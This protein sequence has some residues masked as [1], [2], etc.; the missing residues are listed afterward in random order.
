MFE[1]FELGKDERDRRYDKVRAGMQERGLGALVVYG[2]AGF[3]SSE[4][5]SFVYLTNISTF[6]CLAT[7][8]YLVFPSEGEPTMIG[9]AKF[10]GEKLWVKDIRGKGA[11]YSKAIL[12][13]L[14]E[15]H[16]EK[17]KIGMINTRVVGVGST[18]ER[19]F[20]YI[21]YKYLQDNLPNAHIEDATDIVDMARRI[22]SEA[23]IHCLE[24]GCVAAD[25]GVQAVIET[26]RP[27]V[28][29][30]EVMAKLVNVL[31]LHGCEPDTLFLYGS[32]KDYVDSGNGQFLNPG[33]RRCL[34]AGDMIHTEFNAKYNNYCAQYNQPFAIGE[35]DKEWL[36]VFATAEACVQNGMQE[37]KPGIT[38]KDLAKAL[39]APVEPAG[40]KSLRPCCHGLGLTSEEPLGMPGQARC[41]PDDSFL[42]QENMVF[43]FEPH[44]V[45][46]DMKKLN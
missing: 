37:L 16:L 36:K 42:I 1:L 11:S 13:R 23:E 38:I 39:T 40:L 41:I 9:F 46:A 32:G 6:S 17:S 4:S 27:G 22:K 2:F 44:V 31:M 14:Q 21:T 7:P 35:P 34:E 8:G 18:G 12:S 45:T 43:E 30:F 5:S 24:L 15:L 28:R 33:F 25:A 19:G 20:P 10:P 29:D 26:A 3:D